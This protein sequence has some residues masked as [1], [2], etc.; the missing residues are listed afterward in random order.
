ME[1][2]LG[3]RNIQEK[4][5]NYYLSNQYI[6]SNLLETNK[7]TGKLAKSGILYIQILDMVAGKYWGAKY[8]PFDGPDCTVYISWGMIARVS[9]CQG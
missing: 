4:L 2:L 8:D 3:F 5:R 6:T 9:I 7:N 1:K